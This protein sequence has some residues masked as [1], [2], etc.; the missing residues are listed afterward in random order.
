MKGS[1]NEKAK[2]I[3]E[4]LTLEE[5]CGLLVYDSK[6]VERM[7]IPD[8]N[9]W[10]ESLH[11]L[12]RGG[13]A[14]M[15][16]QAIGLAATF[17]CQL[18]QNVGNVIGTEARAKYNES[19]KRSDFDIY[20]GLTLWSPNINIFRDPRWGRGHETY[21]E[22]PYLTSRLGVS[23]VSGIQENDGTY[24]KAAA[25]AKHFAV[26]SGPEE[27][28]H[29]FNAEVSKIDLAETYLPAFEALVNEAQD[30]DTGT[31]FADTAEGYVTVTPLSL[32]LTAYNQM[33][34]VAQ[35]IQTWSV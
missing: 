12:A 20:K 32:D 14:T 34:E 16:P 1:F 23:F 4:K 9:W 7:S 30:C 3:V 15:F 17:D 33:G 18:M 5:K 29:G 19:S 31:D 10:N 2:E 8:Y 24:M 6:G 35:A 25:C 22:D 11:G 28:R 21:G 13:T 27:L 26:H